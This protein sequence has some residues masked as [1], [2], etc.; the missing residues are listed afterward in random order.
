MAQGKGKQGTD[1]QREAGFVLVR[2][3]YSS[4]CCG[5]RSV[6][7]WVRERLRADEA[8][9]VC[10]W[11]LGVIAKRCHSRDSVTE[12]DNGLVS[13]MGC[14]DCPNMTKPQ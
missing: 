9:F 2:R 1:H 14:A 10:G 11:V 5:M 3:R 7:R 8:R 12:G 6:G 13:G 4:Y